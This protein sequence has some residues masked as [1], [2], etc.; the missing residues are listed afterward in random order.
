MSGLYG[1]QGYDHEKLYNHG[2]G[3]SRDFEKRMISAP[4]MNWKAPPEIVLL[5]NMVY[6]EWPGLYWQGKWGIRLEMM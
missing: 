2:L 3:H 4:R 5:E 6:H 1:F